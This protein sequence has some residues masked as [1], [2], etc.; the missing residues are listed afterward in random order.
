MIPTMVA[1]ILWK[2]LLNNQYGLVNYLLVDPAWCA[3]R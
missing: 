2:W 1:V 3:S